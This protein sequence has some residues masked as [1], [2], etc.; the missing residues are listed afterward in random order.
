LQLR[1]LRLVMEG[2]RMKIYIS[3]S[4][5]MSQAQAYAIKLHID[6]MKQE[7]Q[8]VIGTLLRRVEDQP[9]AFSVDGVDYFDLSSTVIRVS[10]L[11]ASR[12]WSDRQVFSC[13]YDWKLGRWLAPFP[14]YV[15]SRPFRFTAYEMNQMFKV[16]QENS[17]IAL[18]VPFADS[19]FDDCFLT[20]NLHPTLGGIVVEGEASADILNLGCDTHDETREMVFPSVQVSAP[21]V[22]RVGQPL[23]FSL[24]VVDGAGHPLPRDAEVHLESVNGYCTKPR[25]C[26][27]QGAGQAVVLPLGLEAGDIVRLKAGFKFFPA[28]G[29]A[30]VTLTQ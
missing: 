5:F 22:A 24:Q 6:A 8:V 23:A 14:Q 19:A 4:R 18:N 9:A 7:V 3:R 13:A 1:V 30:Q 15:Y 2:D 28:L 29:E 17:L 27:Y 25:V 20:V 16:G 10:E 26:T 21:L 12:N 11:R